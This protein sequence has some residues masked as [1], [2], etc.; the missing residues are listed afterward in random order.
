MGSSS[1]IKTGDDTVSKPRPYAYLNGL[2]YCYKCGSKCRTKSAKK[3]AYTY[4]LCPHADKGCENTKSMAKEELEKALI[5][6]L[7][8]K[9]KELRERA[10]DRY[11]PYRGLVLS[12]MDIQGASAEE[13][14]QFHLENQPKYEDLFDSAMLEPPTSERLEDL[15]KRLTYLEGYPG[16]SANV[17]EEKASVREQIEEEQQQLSSILN[18]STGEIIFAGH[19][20]NFWDTLPEAH[21]VEIYPRIVNRLFIQDGQLKQTNFKVEPHEEN[22]L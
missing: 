17:E 8:G 7:V 22:I 19:R 1:F 21:K 6:E 2:A 5:R 20:L 13:K 15:E 10:R 14:Q 3:G 11:S 4:F 12:I 18:K 9:S 16:H